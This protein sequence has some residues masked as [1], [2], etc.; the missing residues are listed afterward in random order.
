MIPD[1]TVGKRQDW[2]SVCK[3][4]AWVLSPVCVA[5][6]ETLSLW[7]NVPKA[8]QLGRSRADTEPSQRASAFT[9]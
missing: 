2:A 1:G 7:A 5:L 8:T 9:S 4:E 3:S 6:D